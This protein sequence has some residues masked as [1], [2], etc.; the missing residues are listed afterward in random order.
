MLEK[1]SSGEHLL[2]YNV[3]GS[4]A[5]VRAKKDPALGVVL[6]K[7]YTLVLS[8]VM[9]IGKKAKN[10]NAAKLWLDYILSQRGQKM[11]GSDVELVLDPQRRRCAST[12]PPAHQAAGRQRQADPGERR[13]PRLPRSRRSA[14]TSSSM[15]GGDR[16]G[17]RQVDRRRCTAH[18]ALAARRRAACA[19]HFRRAARLTILVTAVAVLAPLL[20]HPLPELARRRRSSTRTR[21]SASAPIEFIFADPRFLA[22]VARIRSCIATAHGGDR[23]AARRHCSPSSWSAPTCRASAG[24]SRCILVPSFVSPMVLAF[25]Y[26]VAAGPGRLL[27]G[28]GD[29]SSSAARRGAS[30]RSPAIAVIAGL[31]ARAQRL[32]LRVVGA[33]EP[34]LR[35][36][37]SGAHR[38]RIAVPRRARR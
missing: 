31:T 16:P 24:S 20:A 38:R 32:R 21:R 28:V 17:A 12:P 14:S 13:D 37:G 27:Y 26:V 35:R 5:V 10:P 6:P 15:E 34:G 29:R 25:G 2:G 36:R 8:R 7:D 1:I 19:R 11:I 33:E 18:S 30:I 9:F 23:R 22:G 3:L 4:Y